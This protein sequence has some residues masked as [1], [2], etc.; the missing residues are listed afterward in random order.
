MFQNCLTCIDVH[1]SLRQQTTNPDYITANQNGV[2]FTSI[3]I[4]FICLCL[5]SD[6]SICGG[7]KMFSVI[8][9]SILLSTNLI[10]L[11]DF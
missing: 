8:E 4:S 7:K 3:T 1:D 11:I 2:D 6:Y 5:F 9:K 10:Y